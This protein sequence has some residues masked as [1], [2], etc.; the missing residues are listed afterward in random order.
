EEMDR[1]ESAVQDALARTTAEKRLV[2]AASHLILLEK[3]TS[4]A[5]TPADWL[6]YDKARVDVRN[7]GNELKVASL[8]LDAP[9]AVPPPP[10][11]L[12]AL[13]QPYEDFC[14]YALQRNN[15]LVENL[16]AKMSAQKTQAA[17][18]V[19]G[20]FH[21]DG[22]T[23]ILRREDVSYVVVTP[24]VGEVPKENHYLDVF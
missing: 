16:L 8:S 21:T 4:H 12:T 6:R 7:V 2:Q 22:L 5:M 17:V 11:P 24:R 10:A 20:G 9:A 1:L 3:L 15:A 18:L 14:A 19:A 23:Q 13:L